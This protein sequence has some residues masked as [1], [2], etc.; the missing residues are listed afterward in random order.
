[1]S[2]KKKKL[3]RRSSKKQKNVTK[4][5]ILYGILFF[6]LS[7][8]LYTFLSPSTWDLERPLSQVITW[9]QEGEVNKIE[10][11]EDRLL[12]HTTAGEQFVSRKEPGASL[13]EI[14]QSAGVDSADVEV[15]IKGS[16]LSEG[17]LGFVLEILPIVLMV[18]FFVFMFRGMRAAGGAGGG[19]ILSFGRS[20]A[21]VFDRGKSPLTFKDVAGVDDAKQE[22]EEVVDFL[23]HPE[24]FRKLGARIPRGVLLVGPSGVGKTLLAKA[25]AG[26]ANVPFF[27][28]SGSEFMEMLVGVGASRVRDLFATAKKNSPSII[29]I[30]ELE[31]IGQ[32]RSG[33]MLGG[34]GEREQTLNQILVEMDGFTPNVNVVVLAATNRPD[35]LDPALI[36]PGRFDRRV[37]LDLP[38]I[39][40]RN[41]IIKIHMRGKPFEKDVSVDDLASRTVGF[42][43]ADLENMLNE[44]A[45]IAARDGKKKISRKDLD[46][47]SLKVKLGPEKRRVRTAKEKE[48]T[49]YH[50]AGHAVV[51]ANIKILD[52][53]QRVSIVSR[54]MALG[55]TLTPSVTDRYTETKTRL[56]G[57]IASA[58]GGRVAEELVFGEVTTGAANDFEKCTSIARKMVTTFGMSDL[59]PGVVTPTREQSLFAQSF[60]QHKTV[61]EKTASAIDEKVREIV[62]QQYARAK[63]ILEENRGALDRVA[64]ELLEKESL[65]GEEFK[66]L[67]ET[68]G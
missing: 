42:S 22:L 61:S 28:V 51:T 57:M 15:E 54:G 35:M 39:E 47:A 9:V 27:S 23:K 41:A 10:V 56:L 66:R 64:R 3:T 58:L 63:S 60:G 8:I 48:M 55:F 13:F 21:K 52:P 29:F 6:I 34:H 24:K 5:L 30:D 49:A 18:A 44:S 17:I 32:H 59:G 40:G 31:S 7:I 53:V 45:I 68:K 67:L 11:I 19:G 12:V 1:M 25:L 16:T 20:H 46:N 26:E 43:G 4:N 38:D 14:L 36:R 37:V 33:S 62:D 65:D 2:A 50:E